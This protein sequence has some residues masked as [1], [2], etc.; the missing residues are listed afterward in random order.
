MVKKN[1]AN[2]VELKAK[3]FNTALFELPLNDAEDEEPMLNSVVAN[4]AHTMMTT[5]A[6]CNGVVCGCEGGWARG[7]EW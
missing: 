2:I 6:R 1:T 5:F 4:S 3:A 7:A